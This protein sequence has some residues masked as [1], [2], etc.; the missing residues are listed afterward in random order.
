MNNRTK[1]KQRFNDIRYLRTAL[2]NRDEINYSKHIDLQELTSSEISEITNK[3]KGVSHKLSTGY[4][5]H[6]IYKTLHGFD[7]NYV[8]SCY[9]YP[10]IMRTLNDSDAVTAFSHKGMIPTYLS[11]LPQ[12]QIVVNSIR[13][14]LFDGAF[15]LI[16]KKKAIDI[17]KGINTSLI[18][19]PSTDTSSGKNV[20][21][22]N[23][24]IDHSEIES[25][26]NSYNDNFVIQEIVK[27]SISTKRFN[28]TSLQTL[29]INTLLLNNHLSIERTIMRVGGA[30]SIV[31][32]L[33]AG[34][35]MV[36]ID[37]NGQISKYGYSLDGIKHESSNGY[38]LESYSIPNFD[39]VVK[40]AQEAHL[41]FPQCKLI[42]W[43]IALDENDNPLILEANLKYPSVV[44][45]Q[46]C[47]APFF[48]NRT[49]EVIDYVRS[50]RNNRKVLSRI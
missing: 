47:G 38:T 12:P 30:N 26:I 50:Q 4:L 33:D 41:R 43:D 7:P 22:I 39:K 21:I 1:L 19:K 17:I 42:G 25:I 15:K 3:W 29:R 6:R 11:Q 2:A 9:F 14:C 35:F 23:E 18:I 13:G 31:D 48:G 16:S 24:N 20:K 40:L 34:G 10:F 44:G 32:N 27:Q 28:P 37:P 36:D 45:V 8:P 5:G 46:L 49:D